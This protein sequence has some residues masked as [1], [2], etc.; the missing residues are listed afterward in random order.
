MIRQQELV[1]PGCQ[2]DHDREDADRLR[3]LREQQPAT[4][5]IDHTEQSIRVVKLGEWTTEHVRHPTEESPRDR[6]LQS[7]L[8]RSETVRRRPLNEAARLQEP[9]QAN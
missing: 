5:P 6:V 1:R 3:N 7:I 8:Q 9:N 4:C 2:A